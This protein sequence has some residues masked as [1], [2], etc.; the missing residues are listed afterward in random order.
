VRGVSNERLTIASR[1]RPYAVEFDDGG[2][3]VE[4][5]VTT[6]EAFVVVDEN[7]WRLHGGG[8]L[9]PLRERGVIVLPVS[10]ERKVYAT[11][12][13]LCDLVI[14]RAAKR[15][16][17]AVSIGGGVTQDVTGYLASTL[18]RGVRWVF[19]PTTL[20]AM[21][22]SCIGGKT[23]L[24][25]GE[26]KN[27]VGTMY[28]PHRVVVHSAFV[29]TLDEDAYFSGLGEVVKLHLLGG[30]ATVDVL[31]SDLTLLL[32]R[33]RGAVRRAA[34]SSL[35]IKKNYIEADEF[36]LGRR[37]LLN[38]GHCFGHALETGTGFAVE[39]GQAVVLGM[40]LADVVARRRGLLSQDEESRRRQ[41]LLTPVLRR[42]PA[43]D[44]AGRRRVVEAMKRDKKRTGAGLAL[45]MLGDGLRPYHVDDVTEG[46]AW[47][48][49]A[50]LPGLCTT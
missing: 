31:R 40:M 22:D 30:A 4:S 20:L 21:A 42:R 12:A 11:V 48:A 38:Y 5:L 39:H 13:E 14:E 35:E 19:A 29:D 46:E 28:P 32:R 43:L 23:S 9:A 49:L 2:D 45:V 37:N 15:N 16:S 44:A 25:H 34:R 36:D 17:V 24:N 41:E 3:W 6:P 50:E 1:L 8:V 47:A 10:E 27:L 18:Y 26:A 7:V 33:E